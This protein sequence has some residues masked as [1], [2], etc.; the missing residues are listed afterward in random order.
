MKYFFGVP[1]KTARLYRTDNS[2]PFRNPYPGT[3]IDKEK[4]LHFLSH[5]EFKRALSGTGMAPTF[6]RFR[7]GLETQMSQARISSEWTQQSDFQKFLRDLFASSLI[8]SIY[9]PSL[10]R[11]NPTFVDDLCEFDHNIPFLAR[12]VPSFLYRKPHQLRA[13]LKEQMKR[14]HDYARQNFNESAVYEDGDGDPFW[15]SSFMRNR[16]AMFADV[17]NH[18]EEAVAALD[19]GLCFGYVT[20]HRP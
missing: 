9:G 7:T 8:E 14:W 16:H 3:T 19:I 1:E 2:G 15:G 20:P 11:L 13:K 4:R 18:D 12:G 6:L 17:G 10:L 5:Q